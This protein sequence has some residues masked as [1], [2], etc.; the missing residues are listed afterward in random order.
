MT[1]LRAPIGGIF[2]GRVEEL[3]DGKPPSAIAK[4]R[5]SVPK[6]VGK[7]GLKGDS[8]ADLSVHGG[9]DKAIHHYAADHYAAWAEDLP[10]LA[11]RLQ[12]GAFGENLSTSG[13]TE[14]S[15]CIGDVLTMGTARVQ[16]SQGRQPCWKLNAHLGEK[17][18]AARFQKT[19]RV[20]WYY[21]VLETGT[22]IEG[23]VMMLVERPQ[24]D[25]PLARV[26]SARFDPKLDSATATS[27]SR[28]P[29]LAK[30]WRAAFA[31]KA[32]GAIE[33][34]DERLIG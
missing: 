31:R 19:G 18:L 10:H 26:A 14:Q 24:P 12:P 5:T 7:S 23:D 34:T 16:V 8:Q 25:W 22:V 17:T 21:R 2:V 28:L 3:W 11:D 33:N 27:L 29:E 30:G 4:R 20:G 15:L 9:P 1:D 32:E 6:L 13:I